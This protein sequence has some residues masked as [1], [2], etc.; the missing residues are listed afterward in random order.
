MQ[1][2]AR[3]A[4][5]HLYTHL[6]G[7]SPLRHT[8]SHPG[9]CTFKRCS[10][11][12][13]QPL[14]VMLPHPKQPA[15]PAMYICATLNPKPEPLNPKPQT[16]CATLLALSTG[17]PCTTHHHP[18]TAVRNCSPPTAPAPAPQPPLLLPPNRLLC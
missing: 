11:I 16:L 15:S 1:V 10:T 18:P 14:P 4:A 5:F 13:P 7:R 3:R 2:W 9:P 6:H 17:P 8:R 12:L